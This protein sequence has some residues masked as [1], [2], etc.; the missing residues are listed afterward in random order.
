VGER[1]KLTL[2]RCDAQWRSV[3]CCVGLVLRKKKKSAAVVDAPRAS[4]PI[5]V[6]FSGLA[7]AASCAILFNAFFNQSTASTLSLA[8]LPEGK[9]SV[10][11]EPSGKASRVISLKYDGLVE[12]VQREL[13][14]TGHFTGL[15]DGVTGPRTKLAIEAYQ[16]DNRMDV[17]G[18]ISKGL[19]EHIKYTRKLNQAAEFTGS[20]APA[21]TLPSEK[22]QPLVLPLASVKKLPVE[23]P[24]AR[25]ADNAISKVQ[26]RLAQLGYDPGSRSGQLDEGTRS[27]ILIFE[28]DH[29][30]PMEGRISKALLGAIKAAEVKR[31]N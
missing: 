15:V 14:A 28:M 16:R 23:K 6:A 30:L 11:V 1:G 8:A 7:V 5:A 24:Q 20:V 13:L 3:S 27:A 10:T 2:T 12:D 19:L 9:T 18:D 31:K 21:A 4:K 17:T 26:L 29:G 25:T 22:K